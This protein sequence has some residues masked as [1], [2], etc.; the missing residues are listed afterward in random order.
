[1][2]PLDD[3][4]IDAGHALDRR[5]AEH[6]R[7]A[8]PSAGGDG[9]RWLALTAAASVVAVAGGVYWTTQRDG[10][11][12]A[13]IA[14]TSMSSVPLAAPT[15]LPTPADGTDTAPTTSPVSSLAQ[16]LT[17]GM[18]GDDVK[19]LQQRLTDLRFAPG[20]VDGVFGE[21]T[22]QAV[23]AYKKLTSEESYLALA[24]SNNATQVDDALWQQMQAPMTIEP[25]R[26]QG[27]GSVHV[28]IYLPQQ[29]L[30]V[31]TDDQPSLIAHVSS[32]ELDDTGEPQ[33]WCEVV[34]Y[35]T[36]P[37]GE[38]LDELKVSDECAYAKTPGGVFEVRRHI[39]G[40]RQGPLGGMYN[41]VYFNYGIA[42]HGAQNVPKVPVSHGCIRINM[43]I[44]ETFPTLVPD[45]SRVFVWG[46]DGREPEE[47]SEDDSLPSFNYPNPNS[48]STT[49]STS[50]TVA[51]TTTVAPAQTTVNV[52]TTA[53]TTPPITTTVTTTPVSTTP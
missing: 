23:W 24:G 16:P 50:T 6:R 22:Q 41:P 40:N 36:G 26:P 44:A 47:Y 49:S 38:P 8:M 21:N 13:T 4:L 7:R 31:F 51:P 1:M 46:H 29:V 10:G 48:T 39:I 34:S 14:A 43:D 28:E 3:L 53:A 45:G 32:G 25:R 18:Y 2:D 30:V 20:P 5:A 12:A 15:T 19:L 11:P 42:V 27:A 9:P 35:D 17:I 33:Q 52:S 37:N